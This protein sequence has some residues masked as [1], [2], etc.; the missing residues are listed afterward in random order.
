MKALSQGASHV[1]Y[2]DSKLTW[3]LQDALGGNCRTSLVVCVSPAAVDASESAG[4][5][6]F[7]A[8]AMK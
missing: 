1:P 3:L 7:G 8:R 2:R 5:L 6:E 4:T